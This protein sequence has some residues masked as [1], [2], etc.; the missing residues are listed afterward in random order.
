[1]TLRTKTLAIISVTLL[2]LMMLLYF[3]SQTILLTSF[4]TLERQGVHQNV[5]QSDPR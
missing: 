1:M 2:G 5:S 4:A 3:I